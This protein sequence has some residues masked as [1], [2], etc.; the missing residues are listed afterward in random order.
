MALGPTVTL[1][2]AGDASA[3]AR[4]TRRAQ[5]DLNAFTASVGSAASSISA[6]G[7]LGGGVAAAVGVA[8]PALGSLALGFGVAA[9]ATQGTSEALDAYSKALEE[10][11]GDF[12][13]YNKLL[14]RMGP[15]QRDFT[16]QLV[17]MRKPMERL[18]R[19]AADSFLPGVTKMLRDSEGLFPIFERNIERTGRIMSDTARDLGNLFSTDRFKRNLDGF[20]RA[21]EPITAQIGDTIVRLTDKMVE[22]GSK[23]GPA[24]AGFASFIDDITSGVEGFLD[25]LAPHA[26]DFRRIWESLGRI[27]EVVLPAV[28]SAIGRL[29][30]LLAPPLE[31]LADFLTRHRDDL[32]E[33]LLAIIGFYATL[34]GLKVAAAVGAMVTKVIGH[35][36]RLPPAAK[37]VGTKVAAGLAIGLALD[38]ASEIPEPEPG[39]YGDDFF[40]GFLEGLQRSANRVGTAWDELFAGEFAKLGEKVRDGFSRL[41]TWDGSETP[42]ASEWWI[43]QQF[44]S[45]RDIVVGKIAEMGLGGLTKFNEFRNGLALKAAE[46]VNN[47]STWFQELPGRVAAWFEGMKT[48]ATTKMT[49]MRDGAVAKAS[50]IVAGIGTWIAQLPGRVVAW[51]QDMKAR[52]VAQLEEWKNAAVAKATELVTRVSGFISQLPGRIVGFF[53]RLPGQMYSIGSNIVS[54]IGR[55]LQSGWSWLTGMVSRLASDLYAS[56]K[57]ALGIGSPSKLFRDEIGRWIPEGVAVGIETNMSPL[58]KAAEGMTTSAVNGALGGMR[59]NASGSSGPTVNFTGNTSDALATVIMHLIRVGQIQIA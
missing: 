2:F 48:S 56:A 37:R 8:L 23:M 29:A 59:G 30:E 5:R 32:D 17:A 47:I 50:E 26:D 22:F 34:K 36:N 19:I 44:T 20:L 21:T 52:A 3:L 10:G 55:G 42:P 16:K 38:L 35:W 40:G 28:G 9:L 24:G 6:L 39:Q 14:D 7:G 4:A 11:K 31:R 53:S 51:F 49:E 45:L 41:F 57:R 15:A 58:D 13:E 25:E 33:W 43:S 12:T 54:S 27:G 46:I 18:Q 1:V